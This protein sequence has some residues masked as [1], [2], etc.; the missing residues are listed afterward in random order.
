MIKI[1]LF[2]T[3][4]SMTLLGSSTELRVYSN[5]TRVEYVCNNDIIEDSQFVKKRVY[6][7]GDITVT[8][9]TKCMKV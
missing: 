4:P 6:K 8:Y 7:N 5:N 1:I 2:L 9:Y 3:I